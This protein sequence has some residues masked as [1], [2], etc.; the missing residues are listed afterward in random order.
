[1]R[2]RVNGEWTEAVESESIAALLARLGIDRRRVAV[3]RN[4]GIV[5]RERYDETRLAE[6][7]TLEIVHF[8]GG[9]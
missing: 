5:P 7:D 9:G 2:V 8:V 1:L 3:E 6:G 4:L